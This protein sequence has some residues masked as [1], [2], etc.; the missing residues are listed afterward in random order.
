MVY[1]AG[2]E[3]TAF[4]AETRRSIQLS[5]EYM[6]YNNVSK[7]AFCQMYRFLRLTIGLTAAL[8]E[9]HF[10]QIQIFM[11][12][13]ILCILDGFGIGPDSINNAI[14]RAKMPNL[15]RVMS[16]YFWTTL[17][18]DGEDVGQEAGL[19]GN[20]E[21]GH[22]N[23]GGLQLVP[24]LSYHITES[25]ESSFLEKQKNQIINPSKFLIVNSKNK[26]IHLIGLFSTGTIH[27]DLRHWIGAIEAA[28]NSG[29]EKIVLHIISDGRDSDKKSLVGT[30]EYFIKEFKKRLQPY[31]NRIFLG[32][33]GGRFYAMDRDNN[34]D[35]VLSHITPWFGHNLLK[36]QNQTLSQNTVK[37]PLQS[38]IINSYGQETLD[39]T[40]RLFQKLSDQTKENLNYTGDEFKNK[41]ITELV[42]Q[43]Q[44]SAGIV[45][46]EA[47]Q[48]LL[49][50]YT[51]I[52]YKTE[53][54]DEYL[55]PITTH[56]INPNDNIWLINFRSDRMK[57]LA[58]TI[59]EINKEFEL[60]LNILTMNDYGI[61]ETPPVKRAERLKESLSYAPIFKTQKVQNTLAQIISKQNKTQL[62]IA[63]TE[64]YAH[65]TYFLNGGSQ[66][67]NTG[68]HW[69]LIPSNKVNSHDQKPEMKAKEITDYILAN[70]LGKYDFIIVNYANPDMVAHTGNITASVESLEFLDRQLGRLIQE[71]E[72]NEHSLII[73]ADHGNCEFVGEYTK[74][75]FSFSKELN[76]QIERIENLTDTEHN[77]NP[78]LCIIVDDK[79]KKDKFN[80]SNFLNEIRSVVIANNLNADLNQIERILGQKNYKLIDDQKWLSQDQINRIKKDQLSLWYVGVLLLAL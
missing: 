47:V 7:D 46:L 8:I 61:N 76:K 30:W 77:P 13:K 51:K 45:G 18:A 14:S 40:N 3:P 28:G 10:T 67:K 52:L 42:N 21:V 24:Q 44:D 57:Q 11:K 25:T 69:E 31:E 27:S 43:L 62:H 80:Q 17:G 68:E 9:L 32:S 2:L 71:V 36:T 5:Y 79:F 23:I 56:F 29:M 41:S 55:I 66:D 6:S 58:K 39:K 4:W 16:Q 38:F 26:T 48:N 74:K 50:S 19:V 37:S 63:E 22:M 12:T 34:M 35:R 59:C 1:S 53:T 78:V 20:S 65:V 70:G 54:F 60:N 15:R 49:K 64:K 73:T 72:R 75:V 33:L